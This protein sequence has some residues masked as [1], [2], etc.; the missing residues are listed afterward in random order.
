MSGFR[1]LLPALLA[2]L[3]LASACSRAPEQPPPSPALWK[4]SG[5]HGEHGYLFGTIHA[6]PNGIRW[7]TKKVDAAFAAST[8]LAVEAKGIDSAEQMT[9]IFER[10]ATTKGMPPLGSRVPPDER[11]LVEN[12]LAGQRLTDRDFASVETWAAA[13]TLANAYQLGKS[14][15][16]VDRALLRSAKGKRVVEFEGVEPQL[17]IFDALP[18]AAQADLLVAVAKDA[19][20]GREKQ[21]KQ[22]DEWLTGD[23]AALADEAGDP[24]LSDPELRQALLVARTANWAGQTDRLL[25][26]GGTLFVAVG[27]AH[28]IGPDGLAA[29]LARRGYTVTRIE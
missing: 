16:G 18:E 4:V 17:H 26:Q 19:A 1:W 23:V 6:L 13:L 3:S 10:L 21:R 9:A 29:L 24:L 14:A 12:A 20:A 22:L 7:H 15:N 28:V 8:T 27:A 5:A 25:K 2:A 11:E